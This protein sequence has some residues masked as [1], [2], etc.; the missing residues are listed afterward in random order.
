M[1]LRM[2]SHRVGP[3]LLLLGSLGCGGEGGFGGGDT[4]NPARPLDSR[5]IADAPVLEPY[6]AGLRV[7]A[8]GGAATFSVVEGTLPPG[9]SMTEAGLIEGTPTWLGSWTVTVRATDLPFPDSVGDVTVNVVPTDELGLGWEHDQLNNM[10]DID[11]G[12]LMSDPWIRI[13][14]G[15]EPGMDSYTLDVGI[16]GPG[17]DGF[18][19]QGYGDDVRVGDLDASAVTATVQSWSGATPEWDTNDPVTLEGLTATAH[20]DT[21]TLM[22]LLEHPDVASTT[23]RI[24]AV[25][26]DWCPLGKHAGGAWTPGQCE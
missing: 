25:P 2:R 9:L 10:Q 20:G 4:A 23:A 22:V 24:I 16:Y 14:G 13:G 12:P 1:L 17:P 15:G 3:L 6:S 18:L 11:E 26:P 21:G 5:S 7:Q 8:W 19:Q